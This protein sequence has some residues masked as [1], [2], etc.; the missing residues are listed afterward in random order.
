VQL[1]ICNNPSDLDLVVMRNPDLVVLAVKYILLENKK[2]IWL[3]N[4]FEFNNIK[5]TGSSKTTLEFDSNKV[6]A[7]ERVR[8]FGIK[9]AD[10]FTTV[11]NQHLRE[12]QLPI[13]YLLFSKTH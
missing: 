13:P 11:P 10:F 2:K 9:V 12:E 8:E 7:K 1:T 4:F 5:H 3:S 6:K